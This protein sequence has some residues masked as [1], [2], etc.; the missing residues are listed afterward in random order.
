MVLPVVRYFIEKQFK[1]ILH[2]PFF[3]YLLLQKNRLRY[4]V[5]YFQNVKSISK[6]QQYLVTDRFC[7]YIGGCCDRG[8]IRD[9]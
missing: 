9:I 8:S 7:F 2:M 4:T 6:V 5:S 3:I 1:N